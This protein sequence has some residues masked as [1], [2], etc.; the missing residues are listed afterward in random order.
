MYRKSTKGTLKHL[1]FIIWDLLCLELSFYI[2]FFIRQPEAEFLSQNMYRDMVLVL[3]LA[4][5]LVIV[6]FNTLK[7]VLKRGY[8]QEFKATLKNVLVVLLLS[9]VWLFLTQQGAE[10]SRFIWIGT[11]CLYLVLSYLVRIV[12]KSHLNS[13][14]AAVRRE[15][16]LLV[17]T[18]GSIVH[19]VIR[20]ILRNNYEGFCITGLVLCDESGTDRTVDGIPVVAGM[21][22]VLEYA[23]REWIDEVFINLPRE[24]PLCTDLINQFI[25]MG[26]TVHLNLSVAEDV[27]GKKQFVEKLS[28]Y[29]VLTY[30]INAASTR[31]LAVKRLLDIAGGLVGCL[32]T[33]IL[34]VVIGPVIYAQ[35]PGPLFFAQERIGKNGRRFKLY[36]FRS[37]YPDAEARKKELMEQNR[38][39]DGLMFKLEND[40]R[41]I[42]SGKGP[43]K[44]IGN[45]IRK[46]SIDEFPQFWNVLKGDM[47]LVG[48]RPPT[49]DE[50]NRYSLHHRARLAIKPGMTG[51][52]QVSGRSEITD[53]DEVVKLDLKYIENW[54]IGLDIKILL[55]T[56]LAVLGKKGSM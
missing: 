52:W 37:M 56:V 53:F 8:Y 18:S 38:I 1:D 10:Y 5:I 27:M 19:D 26:I 23:S 41:I 55:R 16:S 24:L 7:N 13:R 25:Q 40:P 50:W 21:D 30:S 32:C 9:N 33:L 54:S 47:S 51:M 11:G 43:G 46:T 28:S 39:R 45:F 29:T 2:I 3:F 15:R 31:Q 42:G 44:G 48:T 35:S 20:M 49:I 34:T 12:W 17:I 36:K 22:T 6:F 4:D 14:R